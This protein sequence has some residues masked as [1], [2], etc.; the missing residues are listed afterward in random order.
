MRL[1]GEG[2]EEGQTV[3]HILHS[4]FKFCIQASPTLFLTRFRQLLKNVRSSKSSFVSTEGLRWG[5]RTTWSSIGILLNI[6]YS[7]GQVLRLDGRLHLLPVREGG[8]EEPRPRLRLAVQL[9]V[10]QASHRGRVQ[11]HRK[12]MSGFR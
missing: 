10:R 4:T 7:T 5:R 12:A 1:C 9:L 11:G 2:Q 8:E 6:S 3:Q